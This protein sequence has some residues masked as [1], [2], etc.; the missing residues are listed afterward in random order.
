MQRNKQYRHQHYSAIHCQPCRV[1]VY[2]AHTVTAIRLQRVYFS[3]VSIGNNVASWLPIFKLRERGPG[4]FARFGYA[5]PCHGFDTAVVMTV[6]THNTGPST[7]GQRGA[8]HL[9]ALSLDGVAGVG[10]EDSS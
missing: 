6:S 4:G 9:K 5:L 1:L 3:A 2:S 10:R 7:P 8:M